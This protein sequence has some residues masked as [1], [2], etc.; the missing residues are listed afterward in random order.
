MWILH[1]TFKGIDQFL[2]CNC[3]VKATLLNRSEKVDPLALV[4]V[5]TAR[6]WN[7]EHDKKFDSVLVK[8]YKHCTQ[9][10]VYG[11]T[12][13]L[14]RPDRYDN[15]PNSR[16]FPGKICII[17]SQNIF[18]HIIG[19]KSFHFIFE[20]GWGGGGVSKTFILLYL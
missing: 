19:N 1:I 6:F 16:R 9:K 18:F 11:T 4:L 14:S 13:Y 8:L 10:D 15:L 7:H 5:C 12:G 17:I 3:I 2:S 20:R